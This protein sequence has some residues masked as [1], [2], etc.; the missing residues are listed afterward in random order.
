MG[1]ELSFQKFDPLGSF[2]HVLLNLYSCLFLQ[3]FLTSWSKFPW[4][5]VILHENS[6]HNLKIHK[7]LTLCRTCYEFKFI[8]EKWQQS[9]KHTYSFLMTQNWDTRMKK[10]CHLR[11]MQFTQIQFYCWTFCTNY[12]MKLTQKTLF[13]IWTIFYSS[14]FF[15]CFLSS[16]K[17]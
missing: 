1:I 13:F 2:Y 14:F 8:L 12:F 7:T 16:T 17:F 5:A 6:R 9:L 3:F 15:C 11:W 4:V 10:L